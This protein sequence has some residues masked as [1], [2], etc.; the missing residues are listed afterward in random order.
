MRVAATPK[1][2]SQL[3]KLGYHVFV[4]SGAG[5]G[6]SFNDDAYREVGGVIVGNA[7]NRDV[8]LTIGSPSDTQLLEMRRGATLISILR[9]QQDP[10]LTRRIAAQDISALS[11]DM[12]PPVPRAQALDA[13]SSLA[14]VS[15][16]RAVVEAA[17]TFGRQLTGQAT[18]AGKEPPATVLVIGV[19]VAGLAAIRAAT[20]LGAVVRATDPRPEAAGQ[21]SSLGA[22]FLRVG[23][24]GHVAQDAE[25]YAA[26]VREADIIIATAAI[27]GELS[28]KVITAQMVRSM[29]PGSVIVDLA[30][31]AGG[32]C[33]LTRPGESHVTGNGVTIIGYSDLSSRLPGQSSQLYG[34]HLVNLLKL[35]TPQRDG[36]LVIDVDDEVIR[37]MTVVHAGEVTFPPPPV[38][39][40]TLS[41]PESAAEDRSMAV[42]A[43]PSRPWWLPVAW[44]GLGAVALIALLTVA[45]SQLV[46]LAAIL[47]LAVA[48]GYYV[49]WNLTHALRAPQLSLANA[50]CGV[51]LAAAMTQLAHGDW[52]V[53]SIAFVA[54][55]LASAAV[56][57][58]FTVS[59]RMLTLFRRS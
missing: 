56:S 16:Y 44:A 18:A 25:L 58:G 43:K 19:G 40:A 36:K 22:T 30:V 11:M 29:R 53:K 46:G 21:V 59:H 37:T 5:L 24:P 15:G 33:E 8:V 57:G 27:P 50:V 31:S 42:S 14:G 55:A 32:N 49:S 13:L 7:W 1:T 51:I 47:T 54:V 4:E 17:H 39:A 6:A 9:P 20:S 23:Q 45:P 34:T 2:V 26:Q 48:A 52:L 10:S 3:R 35:M 28:P 12:V 38:Q 41:G